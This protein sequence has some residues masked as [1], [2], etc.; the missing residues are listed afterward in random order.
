MNYLRFILTFVKA[1]AL[2]QF[3]ELHYREG[4]AVILY[5]SVSNAIIFALWL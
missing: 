2:Y 1:G 4:E 5:F 3:F